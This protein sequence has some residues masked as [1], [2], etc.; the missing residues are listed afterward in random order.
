MKSKGKK[1]DKLDKKKSSSKKD[2]PVVEVAAVSAAVETAAVVESIVETKSVE[3][4][5]PAPVEIPRKTI[6]NDERQ[7]LISLAAYYRAQK[8]GFGRS[9]PVEDW[10]VAE[11]E[12]DAMIGTGDVI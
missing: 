8:A 4:E 11:R 12:V 6:S 1:A 10:L 7:R 9:N 3:P 2:A 5:A